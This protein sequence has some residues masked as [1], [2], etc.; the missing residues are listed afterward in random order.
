MLTGISCFLN[1]NLNCV[2]LGNSPPWNGSHINSMILNS[3]LFYFNI[4]YPKELQY[5]YS[6]T[7]TD[8]SILKGCSDI[9]TIRWPFKYIF[10]II[11]VVLCF[12]TELVYSHPGFVN[13]FPT[14]HHWHEGHCCCHFKGDNFSTASSTANVQIHMAYYIYIYE[15]GTNT[16]KI[17]IW[18]NPT[19]W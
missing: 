3:L 10:L 14:V 15:L 1:T 2:R 5:M 19:E 8:K 16:D 9:S 11:I 7:T 13:I 12:F 4:H 17:W 6:R 18:M